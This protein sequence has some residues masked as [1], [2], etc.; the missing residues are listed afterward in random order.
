V[1]RSVHNS[2]TLDRAFFALSDPTRRG[3]LERLGRG[4]A[5]IGE[6]AEP[7]GLTLNGVKKHVGILEEVDLVITTKVGRAREC[8]LGP[9]QL[10][11]ATGWIDA[12][13][14]TWERRLDRFGAYV[15]TSK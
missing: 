2:G 5:T 1:H 12:Y 11:D 13:R 7:F 8:R 14:R 9:A 4:P 3:I 15:E 6:L 10:E